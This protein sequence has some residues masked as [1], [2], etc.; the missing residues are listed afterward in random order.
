MVIIDKKK[1]NNPVCV[2]KPSFGIVGSKEPVVCTRPAREWM[3]KLLGNVN[4]KV[5]VYAGCTKRPSYGMPGS[6]RKEC[7][8]DHAND[9]PWMVPIT[10]KKGA[11]RVGPITSSHG[12][13]DVKRE[14][15][16]G[17]MEAELNVDVEGVA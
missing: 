11:W 6:Q 16:D 15:C 1:C 13:G 9:K 3:V 12:I 14:W 17:D 10:P 7:C 2:L 5:C 8:A 4:K